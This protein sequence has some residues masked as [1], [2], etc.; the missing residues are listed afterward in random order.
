MKKLITICTCLLLSSSLF[1]QTAHEVFEKIAASYE[2]RQHLGFQMDIELYPSYSSSKVVER[3]SIK[4]RRSGKK[5]FNQVNEMK[6][7]TTEK[8][9]MMVDHEQKVIVLD[10]R[11]APAPKKQKTLELDVPAEQMQALLDAASSGQ[12][13]APELS[14]IEKNG[15]TALKYT[16][17]ARAEF[18]EVHIWYNSKYMITSIDMMHNTVMPIIED[19]PDKPRMSIRFNEYNSSQQSSSYFDLTPYLNISRKE[20]RVASKYTEYTFFNNTS[21]PSAK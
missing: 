19:K 5:H 18:K 1:A 3:Q 16:F 14:L 6:T 7:I 15:R 13:K 12:A 4:I 17:D 10:Y 21:I 9:Q 2:Q 8:Y 11:P 20:V